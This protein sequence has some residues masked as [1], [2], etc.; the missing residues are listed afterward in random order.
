MPDRE[1]MKLPAAPDRR[2]RISASL[3]QAMEYLERNCAEPLPALALKS[4]GAVASPFYRPEAIGEGRCSL[5]KTT[6]Y[7]G[8]GE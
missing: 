3:Q 5:Q 8:E 4:Y 6:E 1:P 2:A 7:L